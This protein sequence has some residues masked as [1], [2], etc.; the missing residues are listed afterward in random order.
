MSKHEKLCAAVQEAMAA[1]GFN[2]KQVAAF[3]GISSSM[4]STAFNQGI[5]LKEERWRMICEG[6]ALDYDAIVDDTPVQ[7]D[8]APM[9]EPENT[10]GGGEETVTTP[11]E[12]RVLASYLLGHLEED[13][14]HGT[15][16]PLEELYTL[17]NT[18]H[19]LQQ[20]ANAN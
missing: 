16:M 11:D 2:Q 3:A 4:I 14:R 9:E 7:E 1:Q 20:P 17:L 18:V 10:H 19:K 8:P 13:I 5:P 15:D 12:N 6:L